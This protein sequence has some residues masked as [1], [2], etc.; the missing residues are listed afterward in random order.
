MRG[1]SEFCIGKGE[2]E[3]WRGNI[4]DI[5]EGVW[6][7]LIAA[8]GQVRY[9]AYAVCFCFEP[10]ISIVEGS[11]INIGEAVKKLV[12]KFLGGECLGTFCGGKVFVSG[13]VY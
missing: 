4:K 3:T 7:Y 10:T 13:A 12:L 5:A 2:L 9:I 6:L 1:E 8:D 11:E